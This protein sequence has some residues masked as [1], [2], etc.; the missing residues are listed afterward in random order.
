M[1]NIYL[2]CLSIVLLMSCNSD[3]SKTKKDATKLDLN[4]SWLTVKIEGA[5]LNKMVTVPTLDIATAELKI[6]GSDG[7]NAYFG[8]ISTLSN[9][10]IAF[11]ELGSTSKMCPD[12]EVPDRYLTALS[13]VAGYAFKNEV[14]IFTDADKNEV[15]AFLKQEK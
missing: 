5:P 15:L 8:A 11:G 10:T 12:M 6:N 7:C 14:L 9:T 1:K 13:K 2:I 4:G 3:A